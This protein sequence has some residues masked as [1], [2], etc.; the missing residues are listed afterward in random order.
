M[1]E[2]YKEILEDK[3]NEQQTVSNPVE[4]VVMC[5]ITT[6]QRNQIKKAIVK[7]LTDKKSNTAIFDKRDGSAMYNGINLEMVMQ[8]VFDGLNKHTQKLFNGIDLNT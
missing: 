2:E 4:A 7:E 8:C 6:T 1:R 3:L 5:N